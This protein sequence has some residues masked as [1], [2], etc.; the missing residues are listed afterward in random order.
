MIFQRRPV[1][2]I[3]PALLLSLFVAGTL[4]ALEVRTG[5]SVIESVLYAGE[6][7][8]GG[9]G[10]SFDTTVAVGPW[11][12]GFEA[13]SGGLGGQI[14]VPLG[15]TT[16][17]EL[18]AGW[19]LSPYGEVLAGAALRRP[20]TVWLVGAQAGARLDWSWAKGWAV[21]VTTGLR[22]TLAPGYF[23][24]IPYRVLEVPVSLQLVIGTR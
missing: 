24:G 15:W 13:A 4:P 19:N 7:S 20:E 21:G 10:A 2:A 8:W 9:S 14:L 3:L 18:G 17:K 1:G 12:S 5:F 23:A 6:L 11:F 22:Y 16:T